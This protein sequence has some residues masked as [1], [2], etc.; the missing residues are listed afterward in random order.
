[1]GFVVVILSAA[2]MASAQG[3]PPSGQADHQLRVRARVRILE[4]QLNNQLDT[5][6]TFRYLRDVDHASN[7]VAATDATFPKSTGRD[8]LNFFFDRIKL[9]PGETQLAIQA[10]ES[11]NRLKVLSEPVVTVNANSKLEAKF[12]SGREIPYETLRPS[13][14]VLLSVTQFRETGI[15][16]TIKNV[17]VMEFQGDPNQRYVKMDF[18][19]NVSRPGQEVPVN[20]TP[21][22]EV[23]TQF[24]VLSRDLTTGLFIPEHSPFIA[25][26]IKNRIETENTSG[27]PF[28]SEIPVVGAIFRSNDK[29]YMDT[30]LI[31]MVTAEVLWPDNAPLPA[32]AEEEEAE[33]SDESE[34]EPD[35]P[36]SA[37]AATEETT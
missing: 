27:I 18:H 16:L 7:N 36:V 21:Q 1:M 19:V 13:N 2:G 17:E 4:W 14:G 6:F 22:R 12:S 15:T 8:G 25:G 33:E 31:F 9:G 5:G 10:L 24:R 11:T 29:K 32:P 28:L 20:V 37:A 35:A 23:V 26:I 3:D 30:E 34:T